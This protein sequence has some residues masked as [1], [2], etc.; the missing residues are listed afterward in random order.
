MN[1]RHGLIAALLFFATAVSG[2]APADE[3]PRPATF[4]TLVTTELNIEG[5]TGDEPSAA[6]TLPMTPEK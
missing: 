6:T 4:S 5:L 2:P 1:L 3:S